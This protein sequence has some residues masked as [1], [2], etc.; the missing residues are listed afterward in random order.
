MQIKD[1]ILTQSTN[2]YEVVESAVLTMK[3]FTDTGN[4]K[5]AEGH[6]YREFDVVGAIVVNPHTTGTG[7]AKRFPHYLM[8]GTNLA[9]VQAI[10]NQTTINLATVDATLSLDG[11]V[12]MYRMNG[13]YDYKK[14]QLDVAMSSFADEVIRARYSTSLRD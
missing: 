14:G 8:I 4:L 9:N 6:K 13:H 11:Q 5:N 7:A 2:R 12:H 1:N 3:L 10:L